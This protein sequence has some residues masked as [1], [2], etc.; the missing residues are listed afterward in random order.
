M[1]KFF[2]KLN[3]VAILRISGLFL[4]ALYVIQAILNSLRGAQMDDSLLI[5]TVGIANGLFQP[6]IL[7]AL[8]EMFRLRQS[9]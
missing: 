6:L 3:V 2:D 7:L 8:A 5:F 9:K 1:T 4:F